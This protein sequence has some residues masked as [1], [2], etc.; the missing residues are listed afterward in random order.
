M[1]YK[2]CPVLKTNLAQVCDHFTKSSAR[3]KINEHIKYHITNASIIKSRHICQ[4]RYLITYSMEL[5]SCLQT[6][7]NGDPD[8]VK[9]DAEMEKVFAGTTHDKEKFD[10]KHFSDAGDNQP[11]STK[12]KSKYN[13]DDYD[14]K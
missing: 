5:S 14:C 11:E 1:I 7:G 3:S 6:D 9:L 2:Y 8:E 10:I 4:T 13:E 12:L